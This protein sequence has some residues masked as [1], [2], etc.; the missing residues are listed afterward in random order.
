VRNTEFRY[1][2][3]A[4]GAFSSRTEAANIGYDVLANF[5]VT[6]DYARRR[7]CLVPS[8]GFAPPP[9]NRSGLGLS[10]SEPGA[11]TVALVRAGSPG[12]RAGIR[13][14]DKVVAID[15]RAA[16]KLSG[17]DAFK[18][19]RRKAGTRVRLTI[20]RGASLET[21]TFALEEPR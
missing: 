14:G 10:K 9:M 13:E 11:F 21:V 2:E 12:A 17:H 16:A 4:K 19:V 8:P 15:G 18:A 6:F 5:T 7:M 3:D 1:A 20:R